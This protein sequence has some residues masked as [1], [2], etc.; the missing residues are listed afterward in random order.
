MTDRKITTFGAGEKPWELPDD[1]TA[2]QAIA[3]VR[4]YPT[5]LRVPCTLDVIPTA[6]PGQRN[7]VIASPFADSSISDSPSAATLLLSVPRYATPRIAYAVLTRKSRI[8]WSKV[9]AANKALIFFVVLFS[10]ISQNPLTSA[11]GGRRFIQ[12]SYGSIATT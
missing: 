11:F 7:C 2:R 3:P 5:E 8:S 4:G 12:L 9:L 1:E 10:F 6:C